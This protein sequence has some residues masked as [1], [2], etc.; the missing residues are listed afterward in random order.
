MKNLTALN[1]TA[2]VVEWLPIN[3]TH[4]VVI[5]YTIT[6][7]R[8]GHNRQDM[9]NISDASIT[10]FVLTGLRKFTNYTIT[11]TAY[12]RIGTGPVSDVTVVQTNA[13]G[14]DYITIS[15]YLFPSTEVTYSST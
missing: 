4:E 8:Q 13:D 7:Q 2:V 12:N 10:H 3:G 11:V 1:S 9:E 6:W 14:K 15:Y 5:G